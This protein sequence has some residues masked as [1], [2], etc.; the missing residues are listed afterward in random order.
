MYFE[1]KGVGAGS[2][3]K[4]EQLAQGFINLQKLLK[5]GRDIVNER[6]SL[7]GRDGPGGTLTVSF[8]AI[9]ALRNALAAPTGGGGAP[10]VD[11][12]IT[13][14]VGA[15]SL[16]SAV[17]SDPDVGEVW[18]EVDVLDIG[19]KAALTT[20]RLRKTTIPL[21]FGFAHTISI[22]AGSR[23]EE[24]VRETVLSAA[25]EEQE[26]DV[27]F[28]VKTSARGKEAAVAQGFLNLRKLLAQ[29]RDF[30]NHSV[31]LQG[32]KGAAGTLKVS[33]IA[34][35]AL[36]TIEDPSYVPDGGGARAAAP[37]S[38]SARASA[39]GAAPAAAS[40]ARGGGGGGSAVRVEIGAF[41]IS[42]RLRNNIDASELWI[43]VD[44]VDIS[45]D[46]AA[47]TTHHLSKLAKPLDFGYS[48]EVPTTAGSAEAAALQKIIEHPDEKA[49]PLPLIR[50]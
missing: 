42:P 24:T 3:A 45:A 41:S 39:R 10:P 34:L 36:R 12:S 31:P 40:S 6:V 38:A 17:R 46:K 19:D 16:A 15:L 20:T 25:T 9:H 2:R 11:T 43:E 29:G 14:E 18:V 22:A 47:L 23:A 13:V 8:S 49:S 44:L 27:Y 5:G 1:L 32:R 28:E 33:L 30:Q 21:D 50:T 37:A 26:A 48:M 7:N 4:E 35:D